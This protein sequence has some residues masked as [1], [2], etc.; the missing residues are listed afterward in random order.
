P[1][2]MKLLQRELGWEPYGGKHYESVYT[3]FYQGFVLPQKFG[4]DKRRSH[5]SCLIL[6]GKV[7]RAEALAQLEQPAIDPEELRRDRVFVAK[8]LG[9]TDVEL[10][11]IMALPPKAFWDYPS[12]ERDLQRTRRYRVAQAAWRAIAS[13]G[14]RARRLIKAT[15]ARLRPSQA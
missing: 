10:D 12:Y 5:L 11:E 2:A 6:D 8:K 1:R 9:L 15:I 3:K 4:F 7:T 14:T 13:I